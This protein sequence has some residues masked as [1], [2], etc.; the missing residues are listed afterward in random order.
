M[1]IEK[2][3]IEE[4]TVDLTVN[5]R[6]GFLGRHRK[7]HDHRPATA[8]DAQNR[9]AGHI[10]G[11]HGFGDRVVIELLCCRERSQQSIGMT[12]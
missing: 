5:S 7:W 12:R 4:D 9:A 10:A 11:C 6:R 1:G 2:L 3:F 8:A